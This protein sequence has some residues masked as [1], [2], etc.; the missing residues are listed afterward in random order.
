M[1]C[2]QSVKKGYEGH[3]VDAF[4]LYYFLILHL[5]H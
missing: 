5:L 4:Q 3:F 1:K 2:R